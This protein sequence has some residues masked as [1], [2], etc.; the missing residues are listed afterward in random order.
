MES[1]KREEVRKIK[2]RVIDEDEKI[3]KKTLYIKRKKEEKT[4]FTWIK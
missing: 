2:G 3:K 1:I 4:Q